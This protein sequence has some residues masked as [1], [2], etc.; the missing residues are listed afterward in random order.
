MKKCTQCLETKDEKCFWKSRRL[1]SGR[2]S[3]CSNCSKKMIADWRSRNTSKV[4]DVSKKAYQRKRQAQIASCAGSCEICGLKLD[5]SRGKTNA[6]NWDH[7]HAT[8]KF[9]GWLCG[10][11]NKAL[12]LL[13]DNP[14]LLER[15][16]EYLKQK[17]YAP[18]RFFIE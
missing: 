14:D 12:G 18:S 2:R 16:K 5:A 9:R 8:G 1:S 3:E 6:P 13:G 4:I 10:N 11:C 15:A 7:N 17:G